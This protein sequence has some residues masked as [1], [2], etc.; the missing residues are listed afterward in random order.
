MNKQ[1]G[2]NHIKRKETTQQCTQR[3]KYGEGKRKT[4]KGGEK[5][6]KTK[7]KEQKKKKQRDNK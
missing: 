6:L 4:Q 5:T 3:K 2:D 7:D 1:E